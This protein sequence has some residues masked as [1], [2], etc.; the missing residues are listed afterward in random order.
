MTAAACTPS[1]GPLPNPN[2][3]QGDQ[4]GFSV[5]ID[6]NWAM[7][8]A[9]RSDTIF[10]N[11]GKVLVYHRT[12]GNWSL[13]QTLV[14]GDPQ[15]QGDFGWSLDL[16]GDRA[17][18][19][20]F[21][22]AEASAIAGAA[23][24]FERSGSSWAQTAQ[25]FG[26]TTESAFAHSVA[27]SGDYAVVGAPYAPPPT[28]VGAGLVF[29]YRR[30]S[31]GAWLRDTTLHASDAIPNIDFGMSVAIDDDVIV[32]GA[33]KGVVGGTIIGGAAY[34][35]RRSGSVWAQETKL[36]ALDAHY[37]DYFGTSVSV[38]GDT[39]IVGADGDDEKGTDAG[40]AYVFERD[41][42]GVWQQVHKIMPA[43]LTAGDEFGAAVS[44]DD[45]WAI[46]GAWLAGANDSHK[47]AAWMY[48][49][50]N[51]FWG[52]ASMLAP[53][54]ISHG[55]TFGASVSISGTC[56][57]VGAPNHSPQGQL[58]VGAAYIGCATVPGVEDFHLDII[59]CWQP[60]TPNPQPAAATIQ[61]RNGGTAQ[62][63]GRRRVEL[64][65]PNG[66]VT[67]SVSARTIVL[68]PGESISE[69]VVMQIEPPL[70]LGRHELRLRWSDAT[71]E[72]IAR[73]Y[74]VPPASNQAAL[75]TRR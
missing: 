17:I 14:S 9:A 2:G 68:S 47:G 54:F 39:A 45:R 38:S 52:E 50:D 8:G 55:A 41:S 64:V 69:R 3:S 34:V 13:V 30:D 4:A 42:L 65:S 12:N 63:I 10:S 43:A 22:E 71:G 44:I 5:A 26:D 28:F 49:R 11:A 20:A 7:S 74:F 58:K 62:R 61:Y 24:V 40:A 21:S 1:D 59:C 29:V 6:S 70:Q 32:V 33:K 48:H 72:R 25:L 66:R 19:G 73:A 60:P 18:V 31:L 51:S 67:E 27:I 16:S 36:T 23:Y 53:Q 75:G 57:I 56:A 35:F 46:A 37:H 15:T